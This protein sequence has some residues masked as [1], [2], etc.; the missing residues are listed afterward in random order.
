MF[1]STPRPYFTPGKDP[2]PIVQEAGWAPA[3]VWTGGKSRPTGIRSRT[4]QPVAQSLYRLSYPAHLSKVL[5][6]RFIA[7]EICTTCSRTR[8]KIV[9]LTNLNKYLHS[10]T[11]ET[12]VYINIRVN[13]GSENCK[14]KK[15]H[16]NFCT[17]LPR[18]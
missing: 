13:S 7:Q 11:S 15:I 6:K 12:K 18:C 3:P 17:V 9:P 1:S 10:G 14:K 8:Y 16:R 2:V 5:F 4:V